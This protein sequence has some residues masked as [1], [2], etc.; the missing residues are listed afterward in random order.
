[1]SSLHRSAYYKFCRNKEN[2]SSLNCLK[3]LKMLHILPCSVNLRTRVPYFPSNSTVCPSC[4]AEIRPA[5]EYFQTWRD[6]NSSNGRYSRYTKQLGCGVIRL[7]EHTAKWF[8]AESE[9]VQLPMLLV[10]S[11]PGSGTSFHVRKGLWETLK[12]VQLSQLPPATRHWHTRARTMRKGCR[13]LQNQ[14]LMCSHVLVCV[15]V[16]MKLDLV[17]ILKP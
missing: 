2:H 9:I 6:P 12:V 1:M 13:R 16:G 3:N 17:I 15:F 11:E 7:R 14:V 10:H 5:S 8:T 4:H